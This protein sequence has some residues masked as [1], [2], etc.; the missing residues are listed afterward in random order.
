MP[1]TYVARPDVVLNP[2]QIIEDMP[3]WRRF[4]DF[5]QGVDH[6]IINET[7]NAAVFDGEYYQEHM[8]LALFGYLLLTSFTVLTVVILADLIFCLVKERSFI[9]IVMTILLVTELVS[10]VYF[11]FS[12]PYN[13]TMSFRYIVPTIIAGAFYCGKAADKGPRLLSLVTNIAT[14][15]FSGLSFIF[16]C[17]VWLKG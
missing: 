12:Y 6:S 4:L 14:Y 11:C 13:C 16:Y 17:L 7:L 15:A 5:G 3:F 8:F 1:L 9:N 10:Y 2:G